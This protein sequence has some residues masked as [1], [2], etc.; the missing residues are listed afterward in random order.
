VGNSLDGADKQSDRQ[1][2]QR[3]KKYALRHDDKMATK[4]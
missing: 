1:N 4:K 3:I 2:G